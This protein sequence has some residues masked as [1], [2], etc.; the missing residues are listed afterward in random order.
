ME[1]CHV[2]RRDEICYHAH[3]DDYYEPE[4]AEKVL[5]KMEK[6]PDVLIAYSDYFEEK[7]GHKIPANTNLKI[8][9]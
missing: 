8:K 4:Y 5:A 9:P 7:D 2:F 3:Q 1:Q 6:H